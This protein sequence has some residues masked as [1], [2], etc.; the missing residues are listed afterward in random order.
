[1][2]TILIA[3]RGEIAVRV[4]RACREMGIGTVAVYS[5]VDRE[6]RH[7]RYADRAFPLQGNAPG[8]TYL[9]IDKLIAI[10]KASGTDAVH[11]GYGFLA[12]NEDFA[13]AC[14][15]A[16][17]TFIGPTPAV[18]ARMGSKT[19]ARDAAIAAGAPVVPGTQ[20]PVLADVPDA[21][22]Q[23]L[24]DAVGYPLMVKAVAG[25]GGKGMRE[26]RSAAALVDAV[27]TARSEALGAFGDAAVYF[28]RRLLRPRHVEIQLLA[29]QHGTVL[30]FVERECSVQR[31][32]QKVIEE[33][34]APRM[35]VEL[36]ARMA[37]A[38][39]SVARTVGYTNAGTIEFLV[40]AEDR[41]YFLEMNTRLQ[42]EHPVTEMVTG[43]DLVQWQIR[44]ARGERLTVPPEQALVPRGHAIECRV[45]A[46][47]PD[48]RFMPRPGRITSLHVPGG[49]GI[50]DDGGVDVGFEVPIHYDS[51][52]SKLVAWGADREQARTRMLRALS[53]YHVGGIPTTLPFFR[54]MLEQPSFVRGE[55]DTTMLDTE[56]ERRAG[57]PFAPAG[58]G[59]REAAVL[60]VAASAFLASQRPAAAAAQPRSS[61]RGGWAAA[62]RQAALRK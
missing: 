32:H 34:P 12:E 8:E 28:E 19:A 26:V 51:M 7:V 18:I 40:D 25:G 61:T 4:M 27:H 15:D 57:E 53:E 54:W 49:P 41:F 10:A 21:E 59:H 46:E 9:R 42:V 23:R 55:L 2:K 62:A 35:S 3:N 56:L 45:Y 31:R 37:E 38:A 44:I 36:R 30:P 58:D 29:D 16:G 22:V 60:A 20:T 14:V 6:A 17:L 33:S 1:M 39:A 13:Q 48:Q 52:I 43:V 24:A 11:P 47:D 5:E 50:R